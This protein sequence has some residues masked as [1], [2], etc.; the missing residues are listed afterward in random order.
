MACYTVNFTFTFTFT[1]LRVIIRWSV[2]SFDFKFLHYLQ[3]KN[4]SSEKSKIL[5]EIDM[6]EDELRDAKY[7]IFYKH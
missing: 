7:I 6:I 3:A 5:I 2:F 1:T 4:K